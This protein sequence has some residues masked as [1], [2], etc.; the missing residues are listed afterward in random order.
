VIDLTEA[1]FT[2]EE[3]EALDITKVLADLVDLKGL[4]IDTVRTQDVFHSQVLGVE[5]YYYGKYK[6]F[7]R[8]M[9]RRYG[10]KFYLDIDKLQQKIDELAEQHKRYR[11]KVEEE[12]RK[13]FIRRQKIES[14]SAELGVKI[15]RWAGDDDEYFVTFQVNEEELRKLAK[16]YHEITRR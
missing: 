16:A 9:F 6:E 12:Q 4:N 5:V 13:L 10:D 11:D 7:R 1:A 2:R 8:V 14:L 3:L 15:D